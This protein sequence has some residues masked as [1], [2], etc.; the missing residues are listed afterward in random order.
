MLEPEQERQTDRHT[1]AQRCDRTHYHA[2][3]AGGS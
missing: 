3:I 1:H 2:A